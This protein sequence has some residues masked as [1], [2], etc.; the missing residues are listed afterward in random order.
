MVETDAD[1]DAGTL[2]T[3]QPNPAWSAD[4]REDTVEALT[5]DGLVFRVWGGDWCDDCRGQLP[6]FGAALAA[7][8]VPEARV[9]HYPVEKEDDGSKT[10]PLVGEYEIELIPTVVVERDDEEI[11][12]Y[13]EDEQRPIAAY[14]AARL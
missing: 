6:D 9:H 11:A 12:R 5:E 3:M 1:A 7:A 4:A 8:D 14:L 10:G 2:D 13:V